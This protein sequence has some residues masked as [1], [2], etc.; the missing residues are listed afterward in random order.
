MRGELAVARQNMVSQQ[1]VR[2]GVSNARVLEALLAV[3]RHVFVPPEN[4]SQAYADGALTIGEGQTISQPYMVAVMT[5]ALQVESH[6]RVL[7]IGTGSGYQ[8]AILAELA[9]EVYSVERS[10]PLAEDARMLLEEM[11]YSNI[12]FRVGD[13][14][15]GW[16]DKA[17]FD[18]IIVTAGAP[19]VPNELKSQLCE[20][21]LLVI[22]VG[23]RA[24]QEL[25][26]YTR[27][28]DDLVGQPITSCRFVPLVGEEGWSE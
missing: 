21:G 5:E 9:Q 22:P 17:P 12:Q 3:P 28:G 23:G 27:K 26:R 1:I 13:G 8:T 10:Q 14:T 19:A 4:R 25:F 11:G 15:K 24:L 6:H 2:R 20:G 16:P 18:R 7:E